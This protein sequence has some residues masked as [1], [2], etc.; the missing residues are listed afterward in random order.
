MG[1][2]R[3]LPECALCIRTGFTSCDN[4]NFFGISAIKTV[5]TVTISLGFTEVKTAQFSGETYPVSWGRFFNKLDTYAGS[6]IR[7]TKAIIG[8]VVK[9]NQT[10]MIC[11]RWGA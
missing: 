8:T 2:S 4:K 9:A 7:N 3:R 5:V 1:Y 6:Q 10:G 11:Y